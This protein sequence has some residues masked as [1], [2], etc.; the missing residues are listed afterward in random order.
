MRS[1]RSRTNYCEHGFQV[2]GLPEPWVKLPL[3]ASRFCLRCWDEHGAVFVE[4]GFTHIGTEDAC[5]YGFLDLIH[6]VLK[7]RGYWRDQ[8]RWEFLEMEL[9]LH[10]VAKRALIENAIA[11]SPDSIRAYVR[12]ALNNAIFDIQKSPDDTLERFSDAIPDECDVTGAQG[13]NADSNPEDPNEYEAFISDVAA[14]HAQSEDEDIEK[15]RNDVARELLSS[16][17]GDVRFNGAGIAIN[18]VNNP[19]DPPWTIRKSKKQRKRENAALVAHEIARQSHRMDALTTV[20]AKETY[21]DARKAIARLPEDEQKVIRLRFMDGDDF[22]DGRPRSR[23]EVIRELRNNNGHGPVW[24][25]WDL[26]RLESQAMLRL[27]GTR[28]PASFKKRD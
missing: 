10:L 16:Q 18:R 9:R 14:S 1:M 8:D 20:I 26:R 23:S 19:S 17:Y 25:E 22:R 6:Y 11:N 7:E 3:K 12:V 4:K 15:P 28:L 5:Q 13:R 21:N 27:Q 24:S 2:P